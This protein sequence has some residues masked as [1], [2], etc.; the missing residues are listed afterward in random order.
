MTKTKKTEEPVEAVVVEP[1]EHKE[2]RA[3]KRSYS[4]SIFWGFAFIIVGTLI[5]LDN[6]SLITVHFG[7]LWHLW[8]V[9]IIGAGVSM[10]SLRGWLSA[11]VSLVLVL[12]VGALAFFV[13]VDNPWFS[14]S[15]HID[16][17]WRHNISACFEKVFDSS[18]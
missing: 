14:N 4:G 1:V 13:A 5:L 2:R 8:P 18:D 16:C 11:L 7:N 12:A 10:L 15:R 3:K 6:L 9:L 17:E